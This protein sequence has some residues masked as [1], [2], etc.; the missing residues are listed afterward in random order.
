MPTVLA[1]AAFL[2]P[3]R[4]DEA[5]DQYAVAAGLY[6]RGDWKLAAEEFETFLKRYPADSRADQ[7]VFFL[8]GALLQAGRF[9]DAE[10]RFAEYL[11]RAP[12]GPHARAATFRLGEAAYLGKRSE[13]A[14][15]G[16]EA[17]RRAYPDDKLDA[18]AL[19][20]LG[21]VALAAGDSAAASKYFGEAL[22]RFP[23][24]SLEDNCRLGL[25][26]AL[27]DSGNRDEAARY[28]AALAAK[29][30]SPLAD[31]ARFRLGALQYDEGKY[32]EAAATLSDFEAADRAQEPLR[33]RARLAHALALKKLERLDEAVALLEKITDDAELGVDARYHLGLIQKDRRQWDAASRTL[34]AA[35]ETNPGHRLAAALRFHA[36]DA[37]V[38]A[39]RAADA[40]AEFDRVLA[41]PGADRQWDD[42]ALRGKIQAAIQSK[43][44]SAV[45][46]M[47]AEFFSRFPQSPLASDVRR[48][49]ARS[50]LEQKQYDAAAK[51]LEPLLRSEAG[52]EPAAGDRYLMA[53]AM[54]GRGKYDEA[55]ALLPPVIEAAEGSL[56]ADARL[57]QA[58]VLMAQKRFADA[59]A[60]LEAFLAA[61]PNGETTVKAKAQLAIC[62]ARG[63]HM[64]RAKKLYSELL[65][66]H[67][68]EDFFAAT[69]E[70]LAEAAYA[71]DDWDWSAELFGWLVD[72]SNRPEYAT[73]GLSGLGWSQFK[74]GQLPEAAATFERLLAKDPDAKLAAETAW[75]RGRILE[76]LGKPDAAV[77]MYDLV[78]DGPADP[79]AGD[80][81]E[82]LLAAARLR[83]KLHEDDRAAA[84]YERLVKEY[85]KH[86]EL[87]AALYEWSFV[88][89]ELNRDDEA[90]ARLERLHKEFPKSQYWADATCRLAQRAFEAKQYTVADKLIEA[91]LAAGPKQTVAE[92][93]LRLRWQMAA[94]EK[95]WDDVRRAAERLAKDYPESPQRLVADFW[96]AEAAY[97]LGD[98]DEAGRRFES[99]LE[100]IGE[101]R[102]NWMAMIPL[103]RAQVFAQK[104][105][106]RDAMTLASKIQAEYPEFEQQYEV[107][108][109]LGRCL[110]SQADFEAAREAYRRVIR[111]T[112]GAKTETAAMAQWMTGET[113]FHQ[114]DYEAALK[115]YLRVEIL[116]AYPRWQAG[117]LLQAGMCRERLGQPAAAAELYARAARDYPNTPFAEEA[118]RRVPLLA[119]PAVPRA[120]TAGRAGSGTPREQATVPQPAARLP[121]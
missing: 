67:A 42:D 45:D 114:K 28:Y 41:S 60:P 23:N 121:Q 61:E 65:D 20:Y 32:A 92:H 96:I 71:A 58:S 55:L 77:A 59:V 93:S 9:D 17:F 37:L 109:L 112:G 104:E 81:P 40:V 115:E 38:R 82:V 94:I 73:K 84:L 91:V 5:G 105:N 4:A 30:G 53:L 117:A 13:Q 6:A 33:P 98:Y 35:V 69:V 57:T 19:P 63:G 64:D 85:P 110:A 49:E 78:L 15:R 66:K 47:S 22:R 8:A 12:A 120:G 7:S 108:Y 27:A 34:L 74:R 54:E 118:N 10:A 43:D 103:R 11:R 87:D 31:D 1:M 39:G 89:A 52:Q 75:V 14:R 24:S 62:L 90:A 80:F 116:Y 72:R 102:E 99:L 36:G 111:S 18:Y 16:L 119:R 83:D 107:D 29:R 2:G 3:A 97:R 86:P 44:Y 100:R 79:K 113:Y 21:E 70:Q 68:T 95:R 50:L 56:K 51:T 26:R 101:R 106:W 48:L 25:A 46:R 88:L 76:Q